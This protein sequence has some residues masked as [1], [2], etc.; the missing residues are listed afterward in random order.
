MARHSN[1]ELESCPW[2][3]QRLVTTSPLLLLLTG[4]LM[5][6]TTHGSYQ[7]VSHEFGKLSNSLDQTHALRG[8]VHNRIVM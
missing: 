4:S 5:V 7:T 8:M 3:V 6:L 1:P 2:T